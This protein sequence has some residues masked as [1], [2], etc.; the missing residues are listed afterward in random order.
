MKT[1]YRT[2][3]RNPLSESSK[4]IIAEYVI[5]ERIKKNMDKVKSE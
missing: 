1:Q 2:L 3:I 4:K 5:M